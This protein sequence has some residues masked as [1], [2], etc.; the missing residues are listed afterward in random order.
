MRF[1]TDSGACKPTTT[2]PTGLINVELPCHYPHIASEG[3]EIKELARRC[4]RAANEALSWPFR[5]PVYCRPNWSIIGHRQSVVVVVVVA[6]AA[7]PY[8]NCVNPKNTTIECVCL[9]RNT[10]RATIVYCE[11]SHT[12]Q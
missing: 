8:H 3:E 2:G 12:S 7:G 6:T 1:H 10:K 5:F 9:L 4:L 11:F